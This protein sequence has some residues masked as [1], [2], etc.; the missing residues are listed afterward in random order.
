VLTARLRSGGRPVSSKRTHSSTE[1]ILHCKGSTGTL[2]NMQKPKIRTQ[3]HRRR[4]RRRRKRRRRGGGVPQPQSM[5]Y[6]GNQWSISEP[7]ASCSLLLHCAEVRRLHNAV[8]REK[9][10]ISVPRYSSPSPRPRPL[11]FSCSSSSCICIQSSFVARLYSVIHS[12]RPN[13]KTK[14]QTQ[15]HCVSL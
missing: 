3:T 9:E 12:A 4:R 11:S 15:T 8:K 14:T 2:P 7:P 5:V 6:L 1:H 10:K 13:Q